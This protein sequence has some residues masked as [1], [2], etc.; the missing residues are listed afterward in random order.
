MLPALKHDLSELSTFLKSLL[1]YLATELKN[2]NNSASYKAIIYD[3]LD[4]VDTLCTKVKPTRRVFADA[5]VELG[6]LECAIGVVLRLGSPGDIPE[7]LRSTARSLIADIVN[8]GNVPGI[9]PSL[10]PRLKARAGDKSQPK[11]VQMDS[12]NLLAVCAVFWPTLV[13]Q[14]GWLDIFM[15]AAKYTKDDGDDT[16]FMTM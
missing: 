7:G 16:T 6:I 11:D 8:G 13:F 4:D 1:P 14:G 3:F 5:C 12:L 15:E 10:V 9:L 2:N